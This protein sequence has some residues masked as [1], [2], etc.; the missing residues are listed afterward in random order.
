MVW[1][2]SFFPGSRVELQNKEGLDVLHHSAMQVDLCPVYLPG[3]H[4]ASRTPSQR[5]SALKTSK[6]SILINRD[7]SCGGINEGRV[8]KVLM[9]G[10]WQGG[11]YP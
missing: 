3:K 2:M 11:T 4:P 8:E 6:G 1:I 7:L 10:F 5:S 9:A